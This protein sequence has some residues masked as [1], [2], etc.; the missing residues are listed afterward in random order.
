MTVILI[1][2]PHL[3]IYLPVAAAGAFGNVCATHLRGSR[4]CSK[5]GAQV[6]HLSAAI[7]SVQGGGLAATIIAAPSLAA[8]YCL[9]RHWSGVSYFSH[10]CVMRLTLICSCLEDYNFLLS[11]S[12]PHRV[13]HWSAPLSYIV[14]DNFTSVILIHLY[15]K[16]III[17]L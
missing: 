4:Y 9:V 7:S 8:L 10:G 2:S 5:R 13:V 6:S 1:F 17:K 11:L 16:N 14:P 12:Y 3:K 15:D